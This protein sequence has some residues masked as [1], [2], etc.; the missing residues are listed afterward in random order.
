MTL[1]DITRAVARERN[2]S[3]F[4]VMSATRKRKTTHAR[5]EAMW[6]A[7]KLTGASYPTIGRHFRRHHTTVISAVEAVE[8]RMGERSYRTDMETMLT[9]LR[10]PVPVFRSTRK[11]A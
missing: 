7:R 4:A 8:A 3:Y 9:A 5:Q 6:L 11:A 1:S 2:V 10:Q